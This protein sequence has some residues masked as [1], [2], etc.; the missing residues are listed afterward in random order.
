MYICK[1][2]STAKAETIL[3]LPK[4]LVFALDLKSPF[5]VLSR[6]RNRIIIEGQTRKLE[7]IKECRLLDRKRLKEYGKTT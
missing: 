2:T 6:D 5:V 1:L 4:E 7:A 3:R